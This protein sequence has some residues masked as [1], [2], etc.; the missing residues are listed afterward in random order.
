LFATRVYCFRNAKEG[1]LGISRWAMMPAFI[2][3]ETIA[4][5]RLVDALVF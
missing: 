2:D 4:R 5:E 3:V 1:W